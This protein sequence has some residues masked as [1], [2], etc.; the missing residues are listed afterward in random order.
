MYSRHRRTRWLLASLF[1]PWL[2]GAQPSS[3]RHWLVQLYAAD[4]RLLP[5]QVVRL[6]VEGDSTW[7]TLVGSRFT[8]NGRLA[9]D[10]GLLEIRQQGRIV[11]TWRLRR[12]EASEW[13]GSWESMPGFLGSDGRS[14]TIAASIVAEP[15]VF[16][17]RALERWVLVRK[18]PG[19]LSAF[20][21]L[22]VR[23]HGDRL[24]GAVG[25][26]SVPFTGSFARDSFYGTWVFRDVELMSLSGRRITADSLSGDW[27]AVNEP[28][29]G[30]TWYATRVGARRA[31][32]LHVYVPP[33]HH[34]T[35]SALHAAGMRVVPGDTIRVRTHTA[36]IVDPLPSTGTGSVP[37]PIFVEG[38]LPGD[39]L[40]VRVH[41]IRPIARGFS[42]RNL[43]LDWFTTAFARGVTAPPA[44][45]WF[46]ALDTIAGVATLDTTC[47]QCRG[48]AYRRLQGVRI[49]LDPHL[50]NLGVAPLRQQAI[51]SPHEGHHGGNLDYQGVR[52]GSTLFIPVNH[53]GALFSIAGDVHAAQGD[54]EIAGTGIETAAIVD[55]VLDVRRADPTT[56]LRA[57]DKIWLMAFGTA[58]DLTSAT[59]AANT[60]LAEWLQRD[61]QLAPHM[62]AAV[63]GTAMELDIANVFGEYV[64][65]VAKLRK[66]IVESLLR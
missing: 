6:R 7:G 32:R 52:A 18:G 21:H 3:P 37:S 56:Q 30:G 20:F 19:G 11:S 45:I 33:T 16:G 55:V 2:A 31:P 23:R 53:P 10:T 9:A 57:E 43:E 15:P 1:L 63:L 49:P 26:D 44:P 61:Y 8:V 66:S 42:Q 65:V 51:E 28:S 35:Y 46:W 48:P 14:G 58:G 54:G 47:A 38:A 5:V 50:G 12:G 40:A 27:T 39:V 36:G 4:G 25:A 59:R 22:D 60:N 24:V 29:R 41:A 34:Q 13:R 17:D 64:T 62:L